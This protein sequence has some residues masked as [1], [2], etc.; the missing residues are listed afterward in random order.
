MSAE[1]EAGPP[2]RGDTYCKRYV[3]VWAGV[4]LTLPAPGRQ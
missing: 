3:T 4:F 2:F 1:K